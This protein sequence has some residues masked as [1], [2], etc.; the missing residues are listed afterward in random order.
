MFSFSVNAS[1]IV[2]NVDTKKCVETT[3]YMSSG[4]LTTSLNNTIFSAVMSN[5]THYLAYQ[6][7]LK[8]YRQCHSWRDETLQNRFKFAH[9]YFNR[10]ML[11]P[12]S[13]ANGDNNVNIRP[14][15]LVPL[16]Y[17][18]L[19]LTLHCSLDSI[20]DAYLGLDHPV[21]NS[22]FNNV[23]NSFGFALKP[24]ET[25]GGLWNPPEY[26]KEVIPNYAKGR[27]NTIVFCS[28]S[29]VKMTQ[30]NGDVIY[31][32]QRRLM[33]FLTKTSEHQQFH[34]LVYYLIKVIALYR[35]NCLANHF[36]TVYLENIVKIVQN[37]LSDS[38]M[39]HLFYLDS[40]VKTDFEQ[41]ISMQSGFFKLS[42]TTDPTEYY[43]SIDTVHKMPLMCG[44]R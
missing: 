7:F 41:F 5:Q 43:R 29:I 11:L 33:D 39:N 20:R 36:A 25:A 19:G 44:G 10:I 42:G 13:V 6:R 40:L 16:Y 9:N 4:I 15:V 17:P 24:T 38:E 23:V 37:M 8:V 35:D 1:P 12:T 27:T 22:L 31:L 32:P 2:Y 34:G 14:L 30:K 26:T 21:R 3:R 28:W 18:N